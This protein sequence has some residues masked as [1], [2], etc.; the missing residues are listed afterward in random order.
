MPTLD[1]PIT[2]LITHSVVDVSGVETLAA[3]AR[4]LEDE[5]IG[6]LLVDDSRGTR[7]IFTERD[8]VRAVADGADV[9]EA[10]VDDYLTGDLV[11]VEATATVRE[12]L[13]KMR[14]NEIRHVVVRSGERVDGVVSMRAIVDV[15][16]HGLAEIN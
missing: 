3:A 1:L 14:A 5:V 11:T 4:M 2:E 9:D 6:S 12:V 10:R 13:E 8:L 15:L 7:G 16:V